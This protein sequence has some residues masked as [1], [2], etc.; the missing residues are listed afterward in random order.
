M[1]NNV[2]YCTYLH[3]SNLFR[4]ARYLLL[5]SISS[6][7]LFLQNGWLSE[8]STLGPRQTRGQPWVPV[9]E[10]VIPGSPVD[11][12]RQGVKPG[13]IPGFRSNKRGQWGSPVI[14]GDT[15]AFLAP[16][17]PCLRLEFSWFN[18]MFNNKGILFYY[19]HLHSIFALRCAGT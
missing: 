14:F 2:Q 8:R 9:K 11:P 3:R 7:L 10:G 15:V 16:L 18:T 6:S 12:V 5:C 17:G 1:Y 4:P 13:V 19:Y